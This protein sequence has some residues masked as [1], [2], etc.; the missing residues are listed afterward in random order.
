MH[1]TLGMSAL[2]AGLLAGTCGVA[3]AQYPIYLSDYGY[4][5]TYQKAYGESGYSVAYL[6]YGDQGYILDTTRAQPVAY[7][8]PRYAGPMGSLNP[9]AIVYSQAPPPAYGYGA[10]R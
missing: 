10:Y 4:N 6:H 8:Q 9:Y 1:R 3:F 5:T 2:A 7:P